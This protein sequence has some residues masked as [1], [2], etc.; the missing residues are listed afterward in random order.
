MKK[1]VATTGLVLGALGVVFGDIGTSPLYAFQA[2]FGHSG[3]HLSVSKNS[4]YG[5]ISLIIWS[6]TIVVSI[7][8]IGFLMRADNKGEGGIMALVAQMKEGVIKRHN[9]TLLTFLGLIGVALFYGD[10]AITPAISVMSAVEGL[11][12]NTPSLGSLVV[13]ITLIILS[14]L[15]WV[16]KYG[17]NLIGK[18]FGP[19]MLLWFITIGLAGAFQVASQPS[20][21]AALS[22]I[23]AINFY[24]EQPLAAFVSMGAV[25]LAITGAEALYA[26]MGHFG[27]PPISRAWFLLVFPALVLCYMGQGSLLLENPQITDGIFFRLFPDVLRFPVVILA[28]AATL[29]ASQSVISGAFSLTRQAIQLNFLPKM[30]LSYTSKWSA[31]QIYLPLINFLLFVSVAFLVLFFRSSDRLASAY[32]IAVS[33]TLAIDTILFLAVM[34]TIWKK[35]MLYV[36]IVAIIFLS[37]DALFVT[38]NLT[39][40]FHGGWIPLLI[41]SFI[42]VIM[43]TWQRGQQIVAIKRRQ[44]EGSLK[45]FITEVRSKK[46]KIVRVPGQVVYIGHHPG[47]TPLALRASVEDLHELHEKVVIVYVETSNES[48]VPDD[49]RAVF[50]DLGYNDGISELRLTYGFNDVPNIPRDLEKLKGLSPELNFE[51]KEASYFI[52]RSKLLPARKRNLAK[53]RKA[54]YIM[55]ANNSYSRSD[56][57]HLPVNKTVEIQTLVEL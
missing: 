42:L 11:Q 30:R 55:L 39:K 26:D 24:I 4:V 17:T 8:Y 9:K 38:S 20:V 27:R 22:P 2:I 37:V 44:M 50:N 40:I 28:T 21:L 56:Y 14:S 29:I 36:G 18:L 54:L 57:F 31:G 7:K 41:A 15:F 10:S 16:Q 52:S 51:A 53:W 49:E 35:S 19:V 48:H 5:I 1:N 6:V 34:R 33:G 43:L 3:Q 45:K 47:F 46:T 12:V 32:G 23:A 25:V 13:P